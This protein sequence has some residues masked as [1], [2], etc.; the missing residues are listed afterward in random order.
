L[1]PVICRGVRAM[2]HL[3]VVG[4]G[5]VGLLQ[6]RPDLVEQV[7]PE[8][9]LSL[10]VEQL[11]LRSHQQLPSVAQL[12]SCVSS[13]ARCWISLT[14]VGSASVVVSPSG[15]FSATSRSRRRM[16]L[17]L[18]VFGSSGVKTMF[19]GFAIAPIFFATWSRSSA[20]FSTDGWAL[21]FSVTYATI[22]SPVVASLREHTAASA[23]S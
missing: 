2:E 5:A 6:Q 16:I 4:A 1:D 7:D 14:T 15:R 18:R 13:T 17:P 20:S 10:R 21:D 8:P 11:G 12:S 19:A 3:V 23:T 22:A 9:A